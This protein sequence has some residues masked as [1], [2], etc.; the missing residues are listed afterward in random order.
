MPLSNADLFD[1][2]APV[3]RD[4]PALEP[5]AWF[6]AHTHMGENDPDGTTAQAEEIVAGLDAAGHGRALIFAMHEPDGYEAAN[7]AVA[8]A[9]ARA[10]GRLQWLA[11]VDPNAPGAVDEL[12]RCLAEGAAGLK[13]HPRSD[14]FGLPHPVVDE[15]V[16]VCAQTRRPVLFHAGRGIPNLGFAAADLARRHGTP[17]ILAHAGISDLGLLEAEAAEVPDLYFDTAWWN[18]ADLLQLLLTVPPSRILYASDMPY[19]PGTVAAFLLRRAVAEAGLGEDALRSIAGG[20]LGRI[21]AG[22]DPLELGPPPGAGALGERV[23]RAERVCTF[24]AAAV[25]LAFRGADPEETLAL[26]RLGCQHRPGDPHADLLL[27]CDDLLARA[28]A[29]LAAD[30]SDLRRAA[31]GALVAHALAG[32]PSA[33]APTAVL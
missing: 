27:L 9:V 31:P 30:P 20:Q 7:D 33:G 2:L 4:G 22:E 25:Q 13:L 12:R 18:I 29:H 15:L 8:A 14:G 19:A 21:V 11:R 1:E 32:T 23:V 24:A 10:D 28:Q 17:V 26:A 6:D 5:D 16:E 3:L